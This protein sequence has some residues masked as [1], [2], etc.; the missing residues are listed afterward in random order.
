MISQIDDQEVIYFDPQELFRHALY[1][2]KPSA[3]SVC[4]LVC[5]L[6]CLGEICVFDCCEGF[7]GKSVLR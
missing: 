2:Q 1:N 4:F 7:G 3:L 5:D 6:S